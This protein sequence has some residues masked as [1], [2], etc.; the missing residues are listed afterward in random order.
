MG[1]LTDRVV[2]VTGASG[3]IG[4]EVSR[5][6]ADTGATVYITSRDPAKATATAE[7]LRD[8]G[9]VRA[10]DVALDVSDAESVAAF[11]AAFGDEPGRLDILV[12]NAAA[13]VDWSE[14][15]STADLA[16][17]RRVLETNLFGAWQLTAAMLPL[18]RDS[19]H[20]RVVNVSS[21]AGSHGDP[22][23]GLTRRGGAAASYGVSKA[24]VE[25][26]DQQSGH[27]AR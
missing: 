20:A 6:L 13:Y 24:G 1:Q 22:Q 3:G 17:S 9:D 11:V 14:M 18:L 21:G 15:T 19:A 26:A 10:S 4:R 8:H 5:Q 25:C 16:E 12:N 23:F 27:G 7:E 2:V